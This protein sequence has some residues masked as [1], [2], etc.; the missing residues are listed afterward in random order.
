MK[1][2]AGTDVIEVVA[3][4]Y[5]ANLPVLLEGPHGVGKSQLIEQAAR[6][7]KI[8]F[9]VRDLS[10]MEP[11][12]LIGLP[13]QQN[14]LTI[15]APPAFLPT[16][17]QGILAFEELNRSERYM[18]SPC[19]QL[20]TARCLNDYK[21]P[22]GW[23]P[24]AAINPASEGYDVRVL[25]PALQSR[26]IRVQV[27]AD[28]KGWLAWAET[29]GVHAG[30]R[31]YVEQVPD[32]FDTTNPRSWSYVSDLVAANGGVGAGSRQILLA[33]IA[34][35][36]GET[37]AKA[38]LKQCRDGNDTAIR[39]DAVLRKYRSV[40]P[41]VKGWAQARRTDQLQS[42]AHQVQV[43]LQSSDV[44]DEIQKSPAMSKNL[45]D[46]IKDLPGDIGRKVQKAAKQGGAL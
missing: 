34:G 11:P 27:E 37:H 40:R 10:L 43:E 13:V 14:G 41:M 38:F 45:Q 6:Q 3:T 25:D 28:V 30:V 17:G 18:M 21:L 20:L 29:N 36:V 15:Y 7:L 16:K 33:G 42:I 26:F 4:A 8:D 1:V 12:D 32:I 46:F 19:L 2:K 39:V 22:Q 23:L 5:K 35:L 31:Q 44:C 9:I 24:V